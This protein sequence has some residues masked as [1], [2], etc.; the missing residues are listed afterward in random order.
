MHFQFLVEDKSGAILVRELMEKLL[1]GRE[2]VTYDCKNFHGLGGFP[3][4]KTVQDIK[5]GNLLNDLSSHMAGF[6]KSLRGISAAVV[7]VVDNDKRNT[8][9]FQTQLEQLVQQR[10]IS[11]DHV[12]CIAVEEIEAWL[13]G[14]EEAVTMAYPQAKRAILHKYKQDSICGTWEVLADAVYPGGISKLKK[15]SSGYMGI[16][17]EKCEWAKRIG[18]LMNIDDNKSP[19][20]QHFVTSIR[21]RLPVV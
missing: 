13:L 4:K 3:K 7:V 5:T 9:D 6:D 1:L 10:E 18:A 17:E 8:N 14:D 2:D 11:I 12:F 20:F 19:S 16:G 21:S 15:S